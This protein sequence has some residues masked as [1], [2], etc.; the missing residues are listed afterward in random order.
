MF[1]LMCAAQLAA[2]TSRTLDGIPVQGNVD[3]ISK[4]ELQNALAAAKQEASRKISSLDVISRSEIHVYLTPRDLGWL[5]LRRESGMWFFDGKGIGQTPSALKLIRTAP[6]VY[7]FPIANAQKPHRNKSQRRLLGV[8][9]R[10]ALADILGNKEDWWH[11]LYTIICQE[12]STPSI[13]LVFEGRRG[14]LILFLS[15]CPAINGTMN[16]E[17]VSGLMVRPKG[18]NE[19]TL[20]AWVTR[21]AKSKLHPTGG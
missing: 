5:P 19:M 13:G 15:H 18:S 1:T 8:K 17:H 10:T 6:K 16:G 9:A 11:G 3:A 14:T 2:C 20:G 4:P 12:T 7:V 21:Y